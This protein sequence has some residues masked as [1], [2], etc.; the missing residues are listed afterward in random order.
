[1]GTRR[2]DSSEVNH[3]KMNPNWPLP[4]IVFFS[5]LCL[6]TEGKMADDQQVMINSHRGQRNRKRTTS[7]QAKESQTNKSRHRKKWWLIE[8]TSNEEGEKTNNEEGGEYGEDYQVPAPCGYV[9]L[10]PNFV[11]HPCP[12]GTEITTGQE[13]VDAAVFLRIPGENSPLG[14]I[15]LMTPW[16][17]IYWDKSN[18][19]P[20]W[21]RKYRAVCRKC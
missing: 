10:A 3:T 21:L 13:C 16:N 8:T 18:K 20:S 2:K 7:E 9:M 17:L 6:F 19:L 5:C 14:N 15:C 11:A 1:M 12:P 4:L